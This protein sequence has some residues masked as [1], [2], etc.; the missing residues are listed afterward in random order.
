VLATLFVVQLAPS[1]HQAASGRQLFP[2]NPEIVN[3]IRDFTIAHANM[4]KV[5]AHSWDDHTATLLPS[6]KV[7]VAGRGAGMG[8]RGQRHYRS[9]AT[10]A[11]HVLSPTCNSLAKPSPSIAA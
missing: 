4:R 11:N 7:L 9:K 10:P 1:E 8:P 3:D 6:G 2:P 5:L